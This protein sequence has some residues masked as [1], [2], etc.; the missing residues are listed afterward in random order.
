MAK[1]YTSDKNNPIVYHLLKQN[2]TKTDLCRLLNV[3]RL[4]MQGYI[5]NPTLIRL[6]DLITISGLLKVDYLKFIELLISN[7]AT[8]KKKKGFSGSFGVGYI[9]EQLK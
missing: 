9:D 8:V 5:D 7:K 3:S 2:L 6:K 4:T 1:H